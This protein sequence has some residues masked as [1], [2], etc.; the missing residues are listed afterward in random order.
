MLKC[1]R[2]GLYNVDTAI[3]CDCGRAFVAGIQDREIA[4]DDR[5]LV[6]TLIES[7]RALLRGLWAGI[8]ALMGL[9]E[10]PPADIEETKQDDRVDD[11]PRDDLVHWWRYREIVNRPFA[12]YLRPFIADYAFF[13]NPAYN[14]A[15]SEHL[16]QVKRFYA[17]SPPQQSLPLELVSQ[18]FPEIHLKLEHLLDG[19]DSMKTIS[20]NSKPDAPPDWRVITQGA[21]IRV[22][23]T[24]AKWVHIFDTL[25]SAAALIVCMPWP[26]AGTRTEIES[27]KA[28][29]LLNKCVFFVRGSPL[30][31]VWLQCAAK[32]VGVIQ[33]PTSIRV[34]RAGPLR[35]PITM[36]TVD[37]GGA[38]LR[39]ETL[40]LFD[41]AHVE[42]ALRS[43]QRLGLAA[44]QG[45]DAKQL[46][47]ALHDATDRGDIGNPQ[48]DFSPREG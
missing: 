31:E 30:D 10:L 17:A 27:L 21:P 47:A 35:V 32:L 7:V 37:A 23:T 38:V 9:Y 34:V 19:I 36:F 16:Q 33:F 39:A 3:H 46:L 43:L 28:K 25:S 48:N 18:R 15:L 42:S 11:L 29:G 22:A 1:D 45:I 8:Q 4:D 40:D 2:C 20:L 41:R 26:S 5:T 14:E 24:D 6:G 12:L 13:E 44:P